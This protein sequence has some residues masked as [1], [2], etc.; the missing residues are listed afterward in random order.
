MEENK[1]EGQN[2][3]LHHSCD[4]KADKDSFYNPNTE[5]LHCKFYLGGRC[6]FGNDCNRVKQ[7]YELKNFLS[8]G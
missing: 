2:I 5:K 4:S 6:R 3:N 1:D 8:L 7:M